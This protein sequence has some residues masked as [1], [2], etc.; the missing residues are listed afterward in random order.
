MKEFTCDI[1]VIGSG[2]AGL[3]AAIEARQR[4]QS[5]LLA[6]KGAVGRG[7]ATSFAGGGFTV[8]TPWYL[9]LIHI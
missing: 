1:L 8:A 2:A 6:C 7:T 4:A 5:V 9:S 3:V